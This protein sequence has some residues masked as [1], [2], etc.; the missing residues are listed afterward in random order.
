MFS[1]K[2]EENQ[3]WLNPKDTFPWLKKEDIFLDPIFSLELSRKF[4][5]VIQY[6]R[7]LCWHISEL[8]MDHKYTPKS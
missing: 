4:K 6:N 1:Q 2:T 8:K 3:P 7:S 5:C